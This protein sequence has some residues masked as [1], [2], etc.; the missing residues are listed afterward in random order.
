[1]TQPQQPDNL[2]ATRLAALRAE[3]ASRQLDGLIIPRFDAHQGEYIAPHDERLRWISGFT[4][5]AGL[6]VVTLDEAVLF[7]DGR[8][9][10]QA[11][12]ECDPHWFRLRHLFNEPPQDWIAGSMKPGARLGYDPMLIPPAWHDRFQSAAAKAGAS[13]VA[14]DY[15][16]VDTIWTDQPAPPKGAI[17]PL[18]PERTGRTVTEKAALLAETLRT[19]DVDLL[20]E[21]QPDNIGWLLNLRGADADFIPAPHSFLLLDREG[22]VEW[23]VDPAKLPQDRT[24]FELQNVAVCGPELFLTRLRERAATAGRVWID[25][26]YA[27]VAAAQTV[28]DA[29]SEPILERNPATLAKA[30]KNTAEL[31]GMRETHIKD[32]VAWC[33]FLAELALMVGSGRAITEKDAEAMIERHRQ[34]Q[35]GYLHP[36]FNTISA[37]GPHGALCHYAATGMTDRPITKQEIY[38]VDSGGQYPDGTTDATR[39]LCFGI[40]D[41]EISRCYSLVLKGFIALSTLRF[42]K[43]TQ[44]HHID[45]IARRPLWEYG[46]DYDHGTGHGVG[47]CLSVHEQP[48]RIGKPYNPVD[49]LPG[50][51]VTIEP[52]FY[53]AGYFGIRIENEVEIVEEED[54]FLA[55]RPLTLIPIQARLIDWSLLDAGE[56]RW[57]DRYHAAVRDML[58]GKLSVRASAWLAQETAPIK[59]RTDRMGLT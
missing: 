17:F 15:N 12:T 18:S 51:V 32:A 34:A 44:G 7:I 48:Q 47:H 24:G 2:T 46:L 8:Y 26:D 28:L 52:G 9:T 14:T 37:A 5:S 29:G 3:L 42:P 55:F 38:L 43:G 35:S 56:I 54:G 1:M 23:F 21:T 40:P 27:P 10:V 16:P 6:A 39:T 58:A 53:K 4:G 49:L 41:P 33:E 13:L 50:M 22:N 30:V 36:S 20:V 19:R 57:L 25:P 45:A 11:G 31:C 59:E